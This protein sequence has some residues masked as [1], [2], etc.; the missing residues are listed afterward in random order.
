MQWVMCRKV[1]ELRHTPFFPCRA[2]M[3]PIWAALV[4]FFIYEGGLAATEPAVGETYTP[5]CPTPA[6]HFLNISQLSNTGIKSLVLPLP[7]CI[8]IS[9][10]RQ[11][12]LLTSSLISGQRL[13]RLSLV[14]ARNKH[15]LNTTLNGRK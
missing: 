3:N 4:L 11:L 13:P 6:K 2:P 10:V 7:C 12:P 9:F 14:I 15:Q 8:G 1:A 5:D